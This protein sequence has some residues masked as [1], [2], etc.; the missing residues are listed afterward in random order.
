METIIELYNESYGK[1][2]P[3]K[4]VIEST[5]L[6]E[7]NRVTD[8]SNMDSI[9]K[10]Y[11]NRMDETDIVP[12]TI[13][14]SLTISDNYINTIEN[15]IATLLNNAR[16]D[17]KNK[18]N[19]IIE[20]IEKRNKS[21][22]SEKQTDIINSNIEHI[23]LKRIQLLPDELIR[24]ISNYAFTPSIRLIFIKQNYLSLH[25]FIN[26]IK[27][28]NLIKL[29]PS[30]KTIVY[31]I[32]RMINSINNNRVLKKYKVIETDSVYDSIY[33]VRYFSM[34]KTTTKT[35]KV[36][37]YVKLLN[38]CQEIIYYYQQFTKNF[39]K[40]LERQLIRLYHTLIYVSNHKCNKHGN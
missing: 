29:I 28:P 24:C 39:Y 16:N 14:D 1:N 10:W 25:K 40:K 7:I 2:V 11:L 37:E 31:K 36:E 27:S 3:R 30:I 12:K 6:G 18:K 22:E 9:D 23:I 32:N 20:K 34:N 26:T 13:I 21:I 19:K 17:I 38:A 15:H 4:Q 8:I 5:I 33:T 35:K